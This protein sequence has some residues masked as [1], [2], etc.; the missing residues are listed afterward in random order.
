MV[1]IEAWLEYFKK[2]LA[3]TFIAKQKYISR[4]FKIAEKFINIHFSSQ[5]LANKLCLALRHNSCPP[6]FAVDLDIFVWQRRDLYT[7]P[8]PYEQHSSK[9][10]PTF[11]GLHYV[12]KNSISVYQPELNR[13]FFWMDSIDNLKDWAFSA[14]FRNIFHWFFCQSNIHLLHGAAVGDDKSAILI[15]ARGGSGKS[16][17]ALKCLLDGINYLSDDYVAVS[18]ETLYAYS[19]YNSLKISWKSEF[20]NQKLRQHIW[21]EKTLDWDKAIILL[22]KIY[23]KQIKKNLLLKAVFVPEITP[24]T[25]TDICEI[26]KADAL[27]AILPTNL[28]QNKHLRAES[29]VAIKKIIMKLPCFKIRLGSDTSKTTSKIRSFLESP[30]QAVENQTPA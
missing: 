2:E 7:I 19:L 30:S 1:T 5:I 4:S 25:D 10:Q 3:P 21:N 14:P 17:T 27:L 28:K 20:L 11:N 18:S 23:P 9:D 24:Q 16:T 29:V 26:S 15:S 8:P 22:D 13:A 6:P 12:N